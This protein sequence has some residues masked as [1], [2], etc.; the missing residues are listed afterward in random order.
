MKPYGRAA[1]QTLDFLTS[2]PELDPWVRKIP[3]RRE[4]QPTLFILAWRIPWTEE[5][6]GLQSMGS[7]RA[8][9]NWSDLA[10]KRLFSSSSLSA[11]RVVSSAYLRLLIFLAVILMSVHDSPGMACTPMFI[12]ALFATAKTWKQH[13]CPSIEEWITKMWHTYTMEYYTSI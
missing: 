1:I 7:H 3:W 5:P 9:H 13:K 2:K 4:W 6:G 8:G 10:F 12:A 11:I